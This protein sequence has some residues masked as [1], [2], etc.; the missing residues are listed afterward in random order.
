MLMLLPVPNYPIATGLAG[1]YLSRTD[2]KFK[3]EGAVKRP[4]PHRQA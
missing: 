4:L 2:N 3:R 1:P